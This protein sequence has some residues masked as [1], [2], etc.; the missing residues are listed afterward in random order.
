MPQKIQYVSDLHLEFHQNRD[1]LKE[2]PITPVADTLVLAGDILPF[3]IWD[4]HQDL[5]SFFADHFKT[6]YWLPGNHEYYKY[7]A[8]DK[9]GFINEKI[10]NNVLLVNNTSV[11]QDGVKMI[12]T[13]L[14]SR[15]GPQ[16]RAQI[17]ESM[18]DF[19]LIQYN[20]KPFTGDAY[21]RLH[22]DCMD[23]LIAELDSNAAAKTIVFTHHVPTLAHYPEKYKDSILT[24]AFVAPLDN[25]IKNSCPDY[26]IY[27]HHHSNVPEFTVGKTKMLTN[28]LGYVMWNEQAGF[29]QDKY[30]V[31]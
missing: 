26:W 4:R 1:F 17:E 16:H 23:F 7:D 12:F 10:R 5:I 14:W 15:I 27:G 6:T 24:E 11:I 13:T 9:S 29:Q 19:Q 8:A 3:D 20:G 31:I 28:Q 22:Q 21:N 30:L 2:H 25:L 18:M